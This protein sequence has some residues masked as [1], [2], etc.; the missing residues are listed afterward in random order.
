VEQRGGISSPSPPRTEGELLVSSDSNRPAK[1]SGAVCQW[2]TS[3]GL[4]MVDR[5]EI[6]KMV[7]RDL[8]ALLQNI[9]H[10]YALSNNFRYDFDMFSYGY[11]SLG[12][13]R[14]WFLS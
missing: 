4:P 8:V 12:L 10:L 7:L 3:T 1:G 14:E 2:E 9:C 11:E 5:P 13:V 6:L